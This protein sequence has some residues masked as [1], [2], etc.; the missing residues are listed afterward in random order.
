[1]FNM[2]FFPPPLAPYSDPGTGRW[3]RPSPHPMWTVTPAQLYGLITGN[4]RLYRLTQQVRAAP[5]YRQAKVQLLPYVTPFGVYAFRAALG[6][7]TP[8]LLTVVD[9]DKLASAEEAVEIKQRLHQDP[10]LNARLTFISPSR[11]GVKAFIPFCP[12][13]GEA[14]PADIV[15][16][17]E[18]AMEYVRLLYDPAPSD[19]GRGVDTC[20][21]D[22][23]RTCLICHDG[24]AMVRL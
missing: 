10:Y 23:A 8:S 20:G 7:R 5:D 6:L 15:R 18:E 3:L 2:S 14:E 11:L 4:V 17:T 13:S 19:P 22:L 9:V 24:E 1:M 12:P 21:K 16:F